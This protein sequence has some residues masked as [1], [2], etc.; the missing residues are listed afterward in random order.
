MQRFEID[1]RRLRALRRIARK[2]ARGITDEL[3]LPL[4]DLVRMDVEA[5]RQLRHRLV[6]LEGRLR[7]FG[8]EQRGMISTG[9]S[10][11]TRS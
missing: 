7:D 2:H 6:A 5:R 8:F 10:H 4:R 11:P 9:S 3:L 1:R